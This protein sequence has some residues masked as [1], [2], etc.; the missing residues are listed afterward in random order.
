MLWPSDLHGRPGTGRRADGERGT[1]SSQSAVLSS[2]IRRL[3]A[4]LI[5]EKLTMSHVAI[6]GGKD[7]RT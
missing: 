3:L 5:L 7:A 2:P 1:L 4:H 6:P